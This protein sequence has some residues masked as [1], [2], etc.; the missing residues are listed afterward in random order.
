YSGVSMAMVALTTML[1]VK[2]IAGRAPQTNRG[3]YGTKP[4]RPCRR[5]ESGRSPKQDHCSLAGSGAG[6]VWSALVV[7]GP[8]L[9]LAGDR[10]GSAAACP[11]S[12]LSSV[13]GQPAISAADHSDH[14]GF[15]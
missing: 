10:C 13:V 4:R 5:A 11:G 14:G 1:A 3:Q 2:V 15:H 6:S 8:T 7:S 9:C 12:V